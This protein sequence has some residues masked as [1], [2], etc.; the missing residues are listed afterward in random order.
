MNCDRSLAI[1]K[2][3]AV[4]A[5]AAMPFVAMQIAQNI[6]VTGKW[7]ETPM[8]YYVAESYP[9]PL[10]GFAPADLNNLPPDLSPPSERTPPHR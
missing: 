1:A 10:M 7:T 8:Q 4:V 3:A 5:L 2:T 6:G 9:A